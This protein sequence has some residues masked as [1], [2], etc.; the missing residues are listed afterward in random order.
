GCGA[1]AAQG[2]RVSPP[3]PEQTTVGGLIA[4]DLAGPLAASQ[5]RVRDLVIGTAMTTADGKEVRA[6][7]RVVKNVAG[8]D[9]IKLIVGSRGE[10]AVVTEPTFKVRPRPQTTRLLVLACADRPA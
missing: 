3:P 7:G 6:G 5:G 8:Y 2:S 4:A 1:R 10:L 9:L